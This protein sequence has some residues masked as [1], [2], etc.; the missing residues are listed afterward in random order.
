MYK[1]L[2]FVQYTGNGDLELVK[3]YLLPTLHVVR[4]SGNL[5]I[6]RVSHALDTRVQ[7]ALKI[8]AIVFARKHS[9]TP[10]SP[11][12]TNGSNVICYHS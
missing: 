5:T 1:V 7:V 12:T 8:R 4:H 10:P 9:K 11:R 3:T 2:S 6:A